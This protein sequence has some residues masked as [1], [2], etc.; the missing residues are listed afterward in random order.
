MT[1]I[2]FIYFFYIFVS[3]YFLI[4]TLLSYFKNKSTIFSYPKIT[5]NYSISVVIPAYNEEE[6][7][8]ETVKAVYNI[9]YSNI[10]QVIVINDGSKDNTQK[11]LEKIKNK[12]KSLIV[13]NKK[14]SGKAD[15]INTALKIAKGELVVVIDA[16]SY[17]HKD[18]FKKIVGYFDDPEVGAATGTCV[19]RND[20]TFLEKLQVIEYKVIAFTRKLLEYI[21]GIYVIP[22]T[23]AMYRRTALKDIGGFDTKNITEDIEATWHLVHNGWKVKMTLGAYVTTTVP[24]KIKLWYSQRRRWALGGLQC[25]YKYKE[26]FMRK[27]ILGYFILPFFALGWV[28]GLIGI[29]VFLYLFIKN[30]I[31][32]YLLT[33]YSIET[34]VPIMTL[35]DLA[36]TPSVLNYFGLILFGLFLIFTLFVLSIMKDNFLEKQSFFNLLFYMTIYLLIYP[37]VFIVAIWHFFRGKKVWR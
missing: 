27:N 31:S 35:G 21:D 29:G 12:Y 15:S 9:D 26:V 24:N 1:P 8:A 20:K 11:V 37:I 10:V 22:G 28:L 25:T 6:T 18:S 2:S 16:D 36:I 13:I 7:I 4:F 32:S 30:F 33:K 19:P 14:N 17:P 5:K 34:S 3:F 23:L